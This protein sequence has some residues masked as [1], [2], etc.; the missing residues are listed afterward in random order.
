MGTLTRLALLAGLAAAAPTKADP[1]ARWRM[2]IEE[3]SSRFGIPAR[4]VEQVMRAESGGMTKLD[5]RPIRSR[6]GAIGLMQLMP[7]TWAAM[8]A[9]L[10]LGSDPDDPHDN[11]AAGAFYLRLMYDRFG[12]PGLFG[13]YNAGPARYSRSLSGGV[14][15]PS[16][17]RLYLAKVS[18]E[19]RANGLF[20][21]RR[22][23]D[24]APG[25][26]VPSRG[27][28]FVIQRSTQ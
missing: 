2:L 8:R 20:A 26:P 4:W 10:G 23:P 6:A 5:G 11:I 15:L 22:D 13:A 7:S 21:L 24:P 12:Y 14:A 17:T 19:P 28:L 25:K 9:R 18:E 27:T 1:V 16:E 3:A